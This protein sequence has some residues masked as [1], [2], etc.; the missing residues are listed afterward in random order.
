MCGRRLGAGGASGRPGA[1]CARGRPPCGA[2]RAPARSGP[3]PLRGCGATCGRRALQCFRARNAA[4]MPRKQ[5]AAG[6][7]RTCLRLPRPKSS[8]DSGPM[9]APGE[10]AAALRGRASS[11]VPCNRRLAGRPGRLCADADRVFCPL[12]AA[13]TPPA[14]RSLPYSQST[15][16]PAGRGR[17]HGR[18]PRRATRQPSTAR[19]YSEAA[20]HH[21]PPPQQPVDGGAL[22][23]RHGGVGP[24]GVDPRGLGGAGAG[25]DHPEPAVRAAR[26]WNMRSPRGIAE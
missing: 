18:L 21:G 9:H 22:R 3:G 19:R 25:G 12:R 1:A 2:R 17:P 7:R 14:A 13:G 5:D 16:D 24:F 4:S 11:R 6:R 15:P 26:L 23:Q 8:T 20:R 10:I